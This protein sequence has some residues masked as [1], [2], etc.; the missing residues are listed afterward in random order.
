MLTQRILAHDDPGRWARQSPALFVPNTVTEMKFGDPKPSVCDYHVFCSDYDIFWDLQ[1]YLV[2]ENG[3][4]VKL[5]GAK[6]GTSQADKHSMLSKSDMFLAVLSPQTM[7]NVD[8]QHDLEFAIEHGK[9]IIVLHDGGLAASDF[10]D[11]IN[12][13]PTGRKM[14]VVFQHLALEWHWERHFSD[15]SKQLLWHKIC[16]LSHNTDGEDAEEE[17]LVTNSAISELMAAST[18]LKLPPI[19]AS[20]STSDPHLMQIRPTPEALTKRNQVIPQQDGGSVFQVPNLKAP[21]HNP[22]ASRG[23]APGHSD[24]QGPVVNDN[25]ATSLSNAALVESLLIETS[26]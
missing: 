22:T 18:Q 3:V 6:D 19:S 26:D 4:A 1:R 23:A 25:V 8:L 13:C 21:K 10:D 9:K 14:S 7:A 24:T 2:D 17:I 15:V 16:T 5:Q 20:S 11:I 12:A